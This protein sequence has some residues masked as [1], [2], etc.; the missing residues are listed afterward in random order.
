M[1]DFTVSWT[2][3]F[4]LRSSFNFI[5]PPF[6]FYR[7]KM[8]SV[9]LLRLL[10][11]QTTS[12]CNLTLCVLLFLTSSCSSLSTCP[13]QCLCEATVVNCE[14]QSL[15]SIPQSLPENTTTLNL[16]GN[17][18]RNLN[19]ASFPRPLVH[20][21]HLYVSGSQLEALDF[22][23]FQKLPSLR[24]LDLSDNRIS[25]FSIEALHRDN[26]IEVLNF[27]KSL[28]Y[29]SY[30]NVLAD[31]F[32]HS[33]PKV[34]RLDLSNNDLV[35]LPEGIFT[36]LSELSLLDLRNNSLVSIRNG[37]LPNQ[38]LKELDLRDNAFKALPNVTLSEL[39]SIPNLRVRLA[40]NPW[41]CDCDIENMLIWLE[42]HDFVMDR[43]NLTC[44][45]PRELKH[46]QLVHLEHSQLPC[47]RD[48]ADEV[49]RALE[50]S[51]AFLGLV[52]AIIGVIFLL[53]L[54]LNRKGIK[55]WMYNIRDACRDHMEGYHYRYEISSDPQLA[56]LQPDVWPDH[57]RWSFAWVL[58]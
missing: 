27:S 36:G 6:D 13:A 45:T 17:S 4:D 47:W 37:T 22:T 8:S 50:P 34:S 31:L 40:G 26:K 49:N 28:Y 1:C 21:T 16:N 58:V 11:F 3:F 24:L 48:N 39:N 42:K 25:H 29:H 57:P 2:R 12:M 23:V 32:R 7:V 35:F 44:A 56:N 43:L 52:L 14:S 30:I 18:I 53:V 20:L 15:R 41:R 46:T 51:Y 19:N 9:G 38:A 33:L 5:F 55:R 54:Y 10:Q